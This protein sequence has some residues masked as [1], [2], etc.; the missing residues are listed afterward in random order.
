MLR[1]SWILKHFIYIQ[2]YLD[3]DSLDKNLNN[4][5]YTNRVVY[6]KVKSY[7]W[8]NITSIDLSW[9]IMMNVKRQLFNRIIANK[10][11]LPHRILYLP[12]FDW[13]C[14]NH[15]NFPVSLINIILKFLHCHLRKTISTSYSISYSNI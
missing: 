2:I 5:I 14:H 4:V 10:I 11:P 9:F 1:W 13:T 12:I 6:F 8:F 15:R 3:N 7:W